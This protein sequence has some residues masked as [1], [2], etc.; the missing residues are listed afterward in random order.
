MKETTVAEHLW[1][2]ASNQDH[3]R[4]ASEAF[5]RLLRSLL[6]DSALAPFSVK[7][8]AKA[9]DSYKAKSEATLDDGSPKYRGTGNEIMD[10]VA[11]RVIVYTEQDY[12][13]VV[14][15]IRRSF[16][17]HQDKDPGE[18]KP[19]GY[20][21]RHLVVRGVEALGTQRL[22]DDI[23]WYFDAFS[24]A[25]LQVRTIAA[26]AWAEFE[27]HARYKGSE[28]SGYAE[29]SKLDRERVD[30]RFHQAAGFREE[31]DRRFRQI[32]EILT[33]ASSSSETA[34]APSAAEATALERLESAVTSAAGPFEFDIEALAEYLSNRYPGTELQDPRE[35]ATMVR[36]LD[37]L[38]IDTVSGI[39][40]V[41]AE[42]D[43]DQV[44]KLMQHLSAPSRVRRLEDDLLSTLADEFVASVAEERKPALRSRLMK[45]RGKT[46]VYQ[47]FG[48]SIPDSI[49]ALQLSGARALRELVKIVAEGVGPDVTARSSYVSLTANLPLK[50][51]PVRVK[52][53]NQDIWVYS[54][55]NRNILATELKRLV[56][57]ASGM[58]ITVTRAG[59]ILAST[60]PDLLQ[61]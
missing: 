4:Q 45:L 33:P 2:F 49:A 56:G 8:R 29:L 13:A 20:H 60:N 52:V 51:S 18:Q 58:N 27:H 5:G 24:F 36:S 32:S 47:L 6:D 48:S 16:K 46:K 10:C 50:A 12:E 14:D 9:F 53:D 30:S 42:V 35:L 59:D 44:R 43:S 40:N 15:L 39:E 1:Y 34:S 26:H 55:I 25:E 19:N 23:V 21:S 54:I 3:L 7:F 61:T 57:E 22:P 11:G 37:L 31:M 38:K 28:E 41:L 17:V